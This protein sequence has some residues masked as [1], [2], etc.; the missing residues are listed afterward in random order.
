MAQRN[1][2]EPAATWVYVFLALVGTLLGLTIIGTVFW[3]GSVFGIGSPDTCV[4]VVNGR[5]PVPQ[6]EPSVVLGAENG[7]RAE[8]SMVRM[9]VGSP[10]VG[11][12]LLGAVGQ[13][14]LPTFVVFVGSLVLAARLIRGA[15][16]EGIFTQVVAGRLRTLGWFVLAGEVVASL[17]EAQARNWLTNTMMVDREDVFAT[18][19]DVSIMAMFLGVVLISM[20]RIM[21]ISTTMREDIEGTV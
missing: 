16:R 1:P 15:T 20:G 6:S 4:E 18:D 10:T 9:C 2:L 21:R 8:P 19:W 7:V 5:V 3:S 12:R 11:Q 14:R 17:V 13:W